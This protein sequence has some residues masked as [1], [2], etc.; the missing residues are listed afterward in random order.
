MRPLGGSGWR[1]VQRQRRKFC[2]C[3]GLHITAQLLLFG[4]GPVLA[5]VDADCHA[6]LR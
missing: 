4:M 3:L 2:H 5:A 6:A 1:G